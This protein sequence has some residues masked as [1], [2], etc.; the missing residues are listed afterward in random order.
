MKLKVMTYN[1]AGCRD[2]SQA[3]SNIHVDPDA[4]VGVIREL[5]PDILGLNEVDSNLPRSNFCDVPE[6]I[7]EK[8]GFE[9]YYAP[10]FKWGDGFYGNAFA[11]KYH[12]LKSENIPV[13][14]PED[15]SEP[16]SY[17]TRCILHSV[18]NVNG[19]CVNVFVTHFGLAGSERENSVKTLEALIKNTCDPVI[20]MGDFNLTP[21]DKTLDPLRKLLFCADDLLPNGTFS[22]PSHDGIRS[23]HILIDYIMVSKHFTVKNIGVREFRVSDHKPLFATLELE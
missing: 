10:A 14:D 8:L 13:P 18:I 7:G 17:E 11:T 22:F 5:S 6:Y 12:I 3:P 4:C 23:E 9:R 1:I 16:V 15:R 19:I 21:D 20:L 2:Y